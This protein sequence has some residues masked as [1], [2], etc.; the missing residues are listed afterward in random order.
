MEKWRKRGFEG[1]GPHLRRHLATRMWAHRA[2]E[3]SRQRIR[4]RNPRFESFRWN[5]SFSCHFNENTESVVSYTFQ[6][7]LVPLE[8]YY[9]ARAQGT[10]GWY[11][12]ECKARQAAQVMW[13][14]LSHYGK[15]SFVL[16]HT[17]FAKAVLDME[18]KQ[19]KTAARGFVPNWDLAISEH[20]CT[21]TF[22]DLE[23]L[24]K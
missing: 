12:F 18:M 17:R 8:M 9:G 13:N 19:K 16:H 4:I 6:M 7:K 24:S 20:T 11:A 2:G 1:I 21:H 15:V 23:S 14:R 5:P 10:M 22:A 3:I